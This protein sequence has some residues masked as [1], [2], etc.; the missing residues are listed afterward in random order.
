MGNIIIS[1]GWSGY[2]FLSQADSLYTHSVHNHGHGDFGVGL[3]STSYIKSLW[4]QIKTILKQTYNSIPSQSYFLFVWEAEFL[5]KIKNLNNISK[6]NEYIDV[7]NY[8]RDTKDGNLFD[9]DYL[10]DITE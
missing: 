10:I 5:I 7:I 1:D 9:D 3:D 8:I 2:N 6:M 4:S